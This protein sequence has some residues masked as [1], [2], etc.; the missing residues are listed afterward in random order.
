MVHC[1][2]QTTC[3]Y[4]KKNAEELQD[5]GGI[6]RDIVISK[7]IT[8]QLQ[9]TLYTFFPSLHLANFDAGTYTGYLLFLNQSQ[10]TV[11]TEAHLT[12]FHAPNCSVIEW[13]SYNKWEVEI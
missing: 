8:C 4:R 3:S 13:T 2:F 6:L 5:Q 10:Y 1:F 9:D 12:L 11:Q 7:V